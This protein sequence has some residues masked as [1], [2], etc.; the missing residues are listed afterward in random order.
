MVQSGSCGR[1]GRYSPP[2]QIATPEDDASRL[3]ELAGRF[4]LLRSRNHEALSVFAALYDAMLAAQDATRSR[5]HKGMPLVGMSDCYWETGFPVLA[6][7][8][9]ML[10]LCEDAL[11]CQGSVRPDDTGVY[12]RLREVPYRLS[13]HAQCPPVILKNH[14]LLPSPDLSL[15]I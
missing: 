14:G 6:K 2:Q 4:Y 8:Y 3:W 9:L 5:C 13:F 12:F 7:R 11:S 1:L 10:T 15:A